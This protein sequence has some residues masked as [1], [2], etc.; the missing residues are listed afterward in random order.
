[1]AS[2]APAAPPALDA[3]VRAASAFLERLFPAPRE[4]AIRL[5]EGTVLPADGEP[6]FTLVVAA[7]GVLRAMFRPPVETSLGDAFVSGAL[8]VEGD[9]TAAF[10]IVETCRRAARSPRRLLELVRLWRALPPI[11]ATLPRDPAAPA[12]LSGGA[13]SPE[14]DRDAVRFHYDLGNDFYALFLD[15]RMVYSCGYFPTGEEDLEAAQRLKLDH[16]CRKLRLRPGDRLLDIGCGW[17]AL[18]IHAAREYG[19]RGVGIT[20]AERQHELATRRI[21]EAGLQDRLEVRLADYRTL[22]GET[23]DKASSIGMFEHVGR[24]RMPEYFARVYG[25]LRPGGLFLNHGISRLAPLPTGLRTL[26]TDPLNRLVVGVS[27]ITKS[28]FPDTDL[29]PLNKVNA[30]AE[31]AGWEVRDVENLREHYA[32]T[33]R[34]WIA[35]L[36]AREEEA[37]QLVGS[38]TVLA[39]RLYFAASAQR[40][41]AARISVNQTLLAKLDDGRADIPLSRADVYA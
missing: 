36:E 26:I 38:A 10:P 21:A 11:D 23:F 28:V 34:H 9:L 2:T 13:H 6:V 7:P 25:V 22:E 37:E 31:A 20:L 5:W 40:F 39:W 12:R 16:V 30:M 24:A 19:V 1:M 15:P 18:L 14:R 32:I 8:E 35:N 17:G 29:V 33:L 4:F 3:R 27:P 41:D